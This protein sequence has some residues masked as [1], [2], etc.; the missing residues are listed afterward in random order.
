MP[1]NIMNVM[2]IELYVYSFEL[3]IKLMWSSKLPLPSNKMTF[4]LYYSGPSVLVTFQ[5]LS[6]SHLNI[7]YYNVII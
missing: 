3:F 4:T 1:N 2:R 7:S 5:S 6:C